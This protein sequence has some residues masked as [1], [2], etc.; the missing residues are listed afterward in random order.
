M[1]HLQSLHLVLLFPPA[2]DTFKPLS[3][4]LA[5]LP[6]STSFV[7]YFLTLVF[8]SSSPLFCSPPTH[9]HI[10][11]PSRPYPS[12]V[13]RPLTHCFLL[14]QIK[15]YRGRIHGQP[16]PLP[17]PPPF[18][19]PFPTSSHTASIVLPPSLSIFISLP[20]YIPSP[21][22]LPLPHTQCEQINYVA[23]L[24]REDDESGWWWSDKPLQTATTALL[25]N[26]E[27]IQRRWKTHKTTANVQ[28]VF[29]PFFL[30]SSEKVATPGDLESDHRVCHKA[31]TSW[32]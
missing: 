32:R 2:P 20:I 19:P 12:L 15:L 24:E 28:F 30:F 22:S 16:T 4:L 29:F 6:P 17:L 27:V 3:S 8:S 11:P 1:W 23:T 9:T 10:S 14:P 26:Y 5:S 13:S 7:S 18:R 21:P 25:T 31:Q